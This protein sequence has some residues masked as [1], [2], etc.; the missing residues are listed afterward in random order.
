MGTRSVFIK[1]TAVLLSVLTVIA[2]AGCKKDALPSDLTPTEGYFDRAAAIQVKII[3]SNRKEEQPPE[4]EPSEEKDASGMLFEEMVAYMADS[5]AVKSW[6]SDMSKV[7][8]FEGECWYYTKE[9]QAECDAEV[10]EEDDILN[11][12]TFKVYT[13]DIEESMNVVMRVDI[14]ELDTES[15]T[16]KQAVSSGQLTYTYRS[17]MRDISNVDWKEFSESL[18]SLT[19]AE[20]SFFSYDEETGELLMNDPEERTIM[21]D[22]V[23]GPYVLVVSS[24]LLTDTGFLEMDN[25]DNECAVKIIEAFMAA[26]K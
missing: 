5:D 16:Y 26:G 24:G 25:S 8:A 10:S 14:F 3:D 21:T 18:S 6:F 11:Y 4:T 23:N 13:E 2:F 17:Q 22:A 7:S 1:N 15:I 19:T 9:L 20:R 12:T